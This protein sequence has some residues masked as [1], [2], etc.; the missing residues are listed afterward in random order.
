[1]RA[2]LTH[3]SIAHENQWK[4]TQTNGNERKCREKGQNGIQTVVPNIMKTM[5]TICEFHVLSGNEH[6]K[7]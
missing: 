2:L 6:Q 7:E 1:M 5:A 3:L 4:R